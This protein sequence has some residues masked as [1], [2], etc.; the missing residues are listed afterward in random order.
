MIFAS[1]SKF[2]ETLSSI[3]YRL[4]DFLVPPRGAFF[5]VL[6]F[7]SRDMFGRGFGDDVFEERFGWGLSVLGDEVCN[8]ILIFDP[9]GFFIFPSWS[10]G[11][12]WE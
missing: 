11:I 10:V 6:V 5:G 3:F 1:F 9:V 12:R 2:S 4:G 7:C 8:V